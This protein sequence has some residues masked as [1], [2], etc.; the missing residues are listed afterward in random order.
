MC[1]DVDSLVTDHDH[2]TGLVRGLLCH[3]CNV[4]EGVQHGADAPLERYRQKSPA[5]ILGVTIRYFDHLLGMYAEPEEERDEEEF[6][7]RASRFI[8]EL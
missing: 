8:N 5:L 4:L 1:G 6:L 3:Q 7:R 2:K